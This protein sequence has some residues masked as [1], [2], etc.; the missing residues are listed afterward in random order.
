[1]LTKFTPGMVNKI[2]PLEHERWVYERIS[3]GWTAGNAYE[4]L[5]PEAEESEKTNLREQLRM[6]KITL[7]Y[8][9]DEQAILEHFKSLPPN[10]QGRDI[11]PFNSMLKLLKKYDGVRIYKLRPSTEAKGEQKNGNG[12]GKK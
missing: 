7:N 10:V 8:G 11:W 2:A 1:M 4:T 12:S 9:T 6:N 5:I 3:M